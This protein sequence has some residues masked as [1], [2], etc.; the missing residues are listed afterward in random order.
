LSFDD[1]DLRC[2]SPEVE[3]DESEMDLFG[4]GCGKLPMSC[5]W[6][7]LRRLPPAGLLAAGSVCK[8]WRE[9]ARRL[10]RAAEELRLRVPPRS[11]PGFVGSVLQKCP[12]LSRL[13]L[14]LERLG[15]VP[16][17]NIFFQI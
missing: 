4:S 14:R 10:W 6:E 3:I 7:I 5:M 2:D 12:G 1:S 15:S 11:Q 8:G 17:R 13:N 16:E 9:T